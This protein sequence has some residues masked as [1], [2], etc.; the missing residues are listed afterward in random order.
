MPTD[1]RIQPRRVCRVW[2]WDRRSH[3]ESFALSLI[4]LVRQHFV[5]PL[6]DSMTAGSNKPLQFRHRR[7]QDPSASQLAE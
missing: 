5:S 3:V 6:P 2:S 7:H 1:S 4:Q